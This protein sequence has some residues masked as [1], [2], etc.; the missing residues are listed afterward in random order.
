MPNSVS[1]ASTR[2]QNAFMEWVG[3]ANQASGATASISAVMDGV[4]KN[5]DNVATAAG[6]L[7]AVG[8]ARYVGGWTTA[9]AG[10][11]LN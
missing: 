5:I 3:G 9:L 8:I 6:A 10:N 1:A 4:A 11:L 7:V 2:I